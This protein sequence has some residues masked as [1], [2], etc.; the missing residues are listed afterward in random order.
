MGFGCC[1]YGRGDGVVIDVGG[2]CLF[3]GVVQRTKRIELG[4]WV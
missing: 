4:R 2:V 1:W 3:I